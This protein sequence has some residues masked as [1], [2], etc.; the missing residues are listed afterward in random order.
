MRDK[1]ASRAFRAKKKLG[2][3]LEGGAPRQ[4][5]AG[6]H[7]DRIHPCSVCDG[8]TQLQDQIVCSPLLAL[9]I[10]VLLLVA[11]T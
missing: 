3:F 6:R 5:F 7:H 9:I 8:S 11:F 2:H 4:L 1:T 10:T